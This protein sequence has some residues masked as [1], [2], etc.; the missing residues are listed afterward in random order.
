MQVLYE[1]C[2]GIDVHK[3]QVTVAVRT[4]GPGPGRRDTRVRKFGA[5]YEDLLLENQS[6][7]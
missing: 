4:P 1:R 7:D 5:F 6:F 2:A 3:D